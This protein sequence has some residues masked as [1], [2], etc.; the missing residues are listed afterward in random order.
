MKTR[1]LSLLLAALM[2]S[3]LLAGC[4]SEPAAP[5]E[6]SQTPATDTQAPAD[7]PA[8]TPADEPVDEPADVPAD[9]PADEPADEPA[10]APA[11]E[12]ADEPVAMPAAPTGDPVV[13][14]INTR[15]YE[16]NIAT[17][18]SKVENY[19]NHVDLPLV[20]EM[21]T[22]DVWMMWGDPYN[23][24]LETPNDTSAQQLAEELTNVHIEWELAT[25]PETM[26]SLM[27]VSGD[28]PDMAAKG[29]GQT[30]LAN[31]AEEDI[32]VDLTDYI[33]TYAPNYNALRLSDD[34]FARQSKTDD[35]RLLAFYT[36]LTLPG[37]SFMSN[38][39]VTDF[40]EKFG[41]DPV[42]YDDYYD[43]LKFY[44]D[45]L[46]VPVPLN[47][48]FNGQDDSFMAGFNIGI[49]WIAL[50]GKIVHSITQPGYR[51]YVE[52]MHQWYEE[53]LLEQDFYGR[54]GFYDAPMHDYEGMA[55]RQ[56]GVWEVA[57]PFMA[58]IESY[59]DDPTFG[60]TAIKPPVKNAGDDRLIALQYV[61]PSRIDA[62]HSVIFSTC[63]N[64][65]LAVKYSDFWYTVDGSLL[66]CYG[67]EG[68]GFYY[69]DNMIP[70]L[71][72]PVLY[73]TEGISSNM[74]RL[75]FI[76][77][78]W[79]S[80]MDQTRDLKAGMTD[81]AILSYSVWDY[82]WVDTITVPSMA[83]TAEEMEVY[84]AKMSDIT[85]RID[86]SIVPFIIGTRSIDEWDS[87][88]AELEGM[89]LSEAQAVYQAAYDRYL[90]R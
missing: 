43:L 80:M 47:I 39:T 30:N 81:A 82:N 23:K 21:T 36:M 54:T 18:A 14:Y 55:A 16:G 7:E 62:R 4:A 67:K 72:D 60:V 5:A 44:K 11:D 51:E 71:T 42:T 69:D 88:V 41:R 45:D 84:S 26:F 75:Q 73:P 90:A 13:D 65:E 33:P 49:D 2:L 28:Y 66:V 34:D 83:L 52:L 58:T 89:G 31:L 87:F 48:G 15:T 17:V 29:F 38:V 86:E 61:S 57:N 19:P 78:T 1:L 40:L 79:P 59:S 50:D 12:P 27:L 8:D 68:D 70:Q 77:E 25:D 63:E 35:G 24:F 53:G 74:A 85:T 46:Q 3:S 20:D 6:P 32:I 37:S 22:L 76:A 10:D 64:I 56:Y 9:A